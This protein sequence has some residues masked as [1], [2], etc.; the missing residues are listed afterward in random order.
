MRE[1]GASLRSLLLTCLTRVSLLAPQELAPELVFDA[2]RLQ[3]G[4][5]ARVRAVAAETEV[6][7][8][9]PQARAPRPPRAAPAQPAAPEARGGA[10][11]RAEGDGASASSASAAAAAA[12]ALSKTKRRRLLRKKQRALAP[13]G[14]SAAASAQPHAA[15]PTPV[16][17]PSGEDSLRV[18][19]P[20]KRKR[21]AAAEAEALAAIAPCV[22]AGVDVSAWAPFGLHS[23]VLQALA[24]LGF[25]KPTPIQAAVLPAAMRDGRDIIGAAETGSGKTLAFGLPIL[26]YLAAQFADALSAG[27]PRPSALAALVLCPTRELAL[28]VCAHLSAAGRPAGVTAAALVGGLAPA[29]QAR[30]LS[31]C[32]PILVATPG[33]LWEL[34]SG[35]APHL[36]RL[37]QLAF[38]VLDEA[39]RMVEKGH[40]AELESIL[41][42][43]EASK[44][45]VAVGA[46]ATLEGGAAAV[47]RQTFVFSATLTVPAALRKRL[48]LKGAAGRG[49]GRA[50][51]STVGTL[52]ERVPFLRKP[53]VVDV[54]DSHHV[55]A[56]KISEAVIE[57]SDE[58]RDAAL[59]ALLLLHPGRTLVF[60]NAISC[61]RRL[62]ALLAQLRI[63]CAALHA[64][65]QQRQRLRSM[66]RFSSSESLALVATDVAARGLDIP[67]V[68]T[69]IHYQVAP[70]A[71]TY[72]HRSGRTARGSAE[73]VAITLVTPGERSRYSAL[74]KALGK[75]DGLPRFPLEPAMLQ[76]ARRRSALAV[77]LD[78]LQHG[79]EK[80]QGDAAWMARHAAEMDLE[81]DVEAEDPDEGKATAGPT[82]REKELRG[83]LDAL[84]AVP[85][86]AKGLTRQASGGSRK[87]PTFA[88][89]PQA[90]LAGAQGAMAA[91]AAAGPQDALA[92]LRAKQS[93]AGRP[94][95][96]GK[97]KRKEQRRA[98][99]RETC[100]AEAE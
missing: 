30:V 26:S 80:L 57:G 13:A 35:G 89:R 52:V 23:T 66:D 98:V 36:Q 16:V 88:A 61:V 90:Q 67:G 54:T 14:D 43:V 27:Q 55:L 64:A 86:A 58:D 25:A 91:A 77:K 34:A 81:L 70:T 1:H 37:D 49:G 38:L 18:K 83:Q 21:K 31:A 12:A 100:G 3:P 33:R 62:A 42:A 22:P 92:A 94:A 15:P 6:A 5:K 48:Q 73:G 46:K 9:P 39:D 74:C 2:A 85:L 72:V 63:P 69:V 44:A 17:G 50:A 20:S 19:P 41:D 65:Q 24:Q 28:Q 78:G 4:G 96:S 45:D 68:R 84:L 53:R 51:P 56:S 29:K 10:A 97:R 79:R 71:E 32:P 8:A 82:A 7:P 93:T 75:P 87:F 99:A 76:A 11:T 95:G 59:A 47:R 40:F 60:C